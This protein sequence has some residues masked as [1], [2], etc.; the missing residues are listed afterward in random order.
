MAVVAGLK[1]EDTRGNKHPRDADGVV[2]KLGQWFSG[3]SEPELWTWLDEAADGPPR[4]GAWTTSA[5]PGTNNKEKRMRRALTRIRR[6]ACWS[7]KYGAHPGTA[8]LLTLILA[9]GIFGADRDP[10]WGALLGAGIM[11]FGLGPLWLLGCW[12]RGNT[13]HAEPESETTP[14]S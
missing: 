12:G 4:A 9:G 10:V 8:P 6:G 3:F 14:E 7:E 13:S 11:A 5:K 1:D 2:L